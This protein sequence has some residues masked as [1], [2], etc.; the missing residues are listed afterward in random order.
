MLRKRLEAAVG[1]VEHAKGLDGAA[2]SVQGLARRALPAPVHAALRG[3]PLGHALHPAL[4][5][6][7]IG[8]WLSASLL[9]LT[10]GDAKAARRLVA[11]GCLAAL[12]TA[13]AGTADWM[14]TDGAARRVGFVHAGV[15]D[16]A[17]LLYMLSWRS[18]AQ[19]G[20]LNGALLALA[21]SAVLTAGGWLG[22][23][24][25]YRLGVSVDTGSDG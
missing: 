9:D 15:N 2:G 7:P 25:T 16:V 3:E 11:A 5:T 14:T 21:G 1:R 10:G 20:R 17:L 13:V 19:G 22:G 18:R 24:L 4:V 23:H 6:V 12:P 8:T